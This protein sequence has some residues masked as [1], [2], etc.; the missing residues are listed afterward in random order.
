MGRWVLHELIPDRTCAQMACAPY[1]NRTTWLARGLCPY[2]LGVATSPLET[3]AR[4][5]WSRAWSRVWSRV[6]S[7]LVSRD[8]ARTVLSLGK[9]GPHAIVVS[10]R[11]TLSEIRACI[12]QRL[13]VR[14]VPTSSLYILRL[15]PSCPNDHL[16]DSRVFSSWEE[17]KVF[18]TI[19]MVDL[20]SGFKGIAVCPLN[21]TP[22]MRHDFATRFLPQGVLYATEMFLKTFAIY[23][24]T[25]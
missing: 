13:F 4:R 24:S 2:M 7:R 14:T 23:M 17:C 22:V 11:Q 25:L 3:C 1:V 9:T 21:S 6:V 8:L 12:L 19:A 18:L 5:V 15:M 16:G 10:M 20:V